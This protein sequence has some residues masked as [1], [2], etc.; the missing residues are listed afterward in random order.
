[1]PMLWFATSL[2]VD[3]LCHVQC[4]TKPLKHLIQPRLKVSQTR[5]HYVQSCFAR[6]LTWNPFL[7]C[8]C[9]SQRHEKRH[10]SRRNDRISDHVPQSLT[11]IDRRQHDVSGDLLNAVASSWCLTTM[12]FLKHLLVESLVVKIV[13]FSQCCARNA[14]ISRG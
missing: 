9:D 14:E 10:T 1:M 3:D 4:E 13:P 2:L 6:L 5:S 7:S 11:D 8:H 12:K